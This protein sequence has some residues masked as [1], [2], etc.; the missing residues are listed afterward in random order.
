MDLFQFPE[1]KKNNFLA[2]VKRFTFSK[3]G[4]NG[5]NNRIP[6]INNRL[7]KHIIMLSCFYVLML[8]C[9]AESMKM[10]DPLFYLNSLPKIYCFK[11]PEEKCIRNNIRKRCRKKKKKAA[12]GFLLSPHYFLSL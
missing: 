1:K 5:N 12:I 11:E 7:E 8:S 10:F 9:F 4:K 6:R 2:N 3:C